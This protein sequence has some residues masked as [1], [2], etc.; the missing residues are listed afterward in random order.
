MTT[1][2]TT[3]WPLTFTGDSEIQ[4]EHQI[5]YLCIHILNISRGLLVFDFRIR[6]AFIIRQCD[7]RFRISCIINYFTVV[8]SNSTLP[9]TSTTPTHKS[10]TA[11][12]TQITT[13]LITSTKAS[14]NHTTSSVTN[15]TTTS[16]P[17]VSTTTSPTT[18]PA[19]KT[20]TSPTTGSGTTPTTTPAPGKRHFNIES[21]IGGFVLCG[22]IVAI[23]YFAYR[24]YKSRQDR[25]YQQF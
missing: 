4:Q 13:T 7:Y 15:V 2:L 1:F 9:Q 10:T 12:P 23:I 24:F 11:A 6:L 19:S 16:N 22:V 14:T 21:F 18:T 25:N 20:T 17:V 5:H 8:G 3:C